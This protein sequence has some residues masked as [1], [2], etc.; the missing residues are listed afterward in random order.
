MEALPDDS[1]AVRINGAY[2]GG[3]IGRPARLDV[4]R[5]LKAGENTVLIEPLSPKSARIVGYG[6]AGQ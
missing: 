4:T 1:A 2:A 3:V 6:A 5:Y